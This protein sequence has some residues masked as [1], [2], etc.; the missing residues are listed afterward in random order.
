M[1]KQQKIVRVTLTAS[2]LAEISSALGAAFLARLDS[3]GTVERY[4]Q[5]YGN[6]IFSDLEQ[7]IADAKNRIRAAA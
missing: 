2:E 6:K 4:K 1:N 5:V 7:K 3:V